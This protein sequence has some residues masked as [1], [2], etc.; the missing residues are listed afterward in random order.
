[1]IQVDLGK[2]RDS[3]DDLI[4]SLIGLA[5]SFHR[6]HF[7]VRAFVHLYAFLVERERL[8][9]PQSRLLHRVALTFIEHDVQYGSDFLAMFSCTAIVSV[10]VLS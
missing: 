8:C 9:V 4:E 1:M 6:I 7:A 2:S 10:E 3:F 5:Q